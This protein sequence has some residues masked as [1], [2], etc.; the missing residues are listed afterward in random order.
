MNT[1]LQS[2]GEASSLLLVDDEQSAQALAAALRTSG[3]RVETATTVAAAV[4][5]ARQ[6]GYRYAITALRLPDDSGLHLVRA[7]LA[8]D[9]TMRIGVLTGYPSIQTAVEAIKLGAVSYL[10][11]PAT[12]EQLI[13]A[14]HSDEGDPGVPLGDKPMSM[15]RLAWEHISHVLHENNGNVSAT[16]RAL[17]IHRRTLQRKLRKRPAAA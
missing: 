16:A 6:N 9:P 12:A 17:A 5:L 7:L 13:A 8:I 15:H 11:K 10:V 1:G 14:L 2:N 4:A 3:L